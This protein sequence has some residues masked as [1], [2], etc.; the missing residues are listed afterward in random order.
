MGF[1]ATDSWYLANSVPRCD[2][3]Y[4]LIDYLHRDEAK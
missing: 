3:R 4:G 1:L 2:T